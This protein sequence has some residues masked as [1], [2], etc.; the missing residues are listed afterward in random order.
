MIRLAKVLAISLLLAACAGSNPYYDPSKSHHRPNGFNNNYID[1]STIGDGLLKWRWDALIHGIPEQHLERV[2]R[3]AP[4]LALLRANRS[5]VTVTF[6]GHATAFWQIAGLNVLTDPQFSERASPV[7][8]AGPKR[9]IPLPMQLKDLPHVDLVLVSHNH[10]DH[11]DLDTVLALNQQAGGPPLFVVPLGVDL[12]MKEQG[13][14]NVK[15]LDWWD[16]HPVG[17]A[18]VT[19][20]PVQHWSSRTPFDRHHT[21]WGGFVLQAPVAGQPYSMFFTGDTG[22]SADFKNIGVKFGGFDFSQIAVGCYAPRWFM[23]DQHV[24]ED[25][26]VKI[27]L[28]VKSRLSM[29][30]HWGAFRLCD[31]PLEAPI[32]GL[33]KARAAHGVADDAFVLFAIGETRVLK[34]GP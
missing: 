33:P 23:H 7:G 29:G 13:I 10:Y 17:A 24:D 20:V 8:F 32:D 30:V 3:K 27:H 6:I 22:Y 18:K 34:Q 2:P 5:D 1:N 14:T 11:L 4:D 26:A 19:L 21:L 25:A 15:A 28:D 16:S 31:D 12:W 9:L